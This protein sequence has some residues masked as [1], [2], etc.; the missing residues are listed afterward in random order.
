MFWNFQKIMLKPFSI[1]ILMGI[2]LAVFEICDDNRNIDAT[3]YF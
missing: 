3:K 1:K 2:A